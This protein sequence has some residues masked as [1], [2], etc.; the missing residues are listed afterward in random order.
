MHIPTRT[1]PPKK[2]ELPGQ[3]TRWKSP[4]GLPLAACVAAWITFG[5]LALSPSAIAQAVPL[6]AAEDFAVLGGSTVTNT[7][8]SIITGDVGVSPGT[9]ITGFPP[10]V[11]VGGT[12]RSND[13]VAQ[14][15]HLAAANAF[16]QVGLE[17]A[18]I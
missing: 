16:N 17:L 5:L 6:G 14:Q 11:V 12:I 8:A 4:V 7:G 1:L 15:A 10:G 3:S 18:T 2:N 13:A 9:A